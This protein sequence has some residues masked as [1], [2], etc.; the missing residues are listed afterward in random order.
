LAILLAWIMAAAIIPICI[1]QY[2]WAHSLRPIDI[3]LHG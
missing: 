1:A 2:P 3:I